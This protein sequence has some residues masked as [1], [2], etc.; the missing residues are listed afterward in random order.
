ML[1]SVALVVLTRAIRRNVAEDAV[2]LL[3]M[4]AESEKLGQH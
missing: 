2:L 1:R 3:W 4:I